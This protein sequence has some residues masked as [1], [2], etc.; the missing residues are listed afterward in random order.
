MPNEEDGLSS[1]H[2]RNDTLTSSI[3]N[4]QAMLNRPSNLTNK[5]SNTSMDTN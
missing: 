1:I 2:M 4:L 3:G 5:D